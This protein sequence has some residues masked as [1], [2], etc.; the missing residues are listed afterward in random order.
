MEDSSPL[1]GEMAEGRFLR[2]IGGAAGVAI[3]I[4]S[5]FWPIYPLAGIAASASDHSATRY[6]GPSFGI[7]SSLKGVR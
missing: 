3:K 4:M 5:W 2:R 1:H 6:K 7:E